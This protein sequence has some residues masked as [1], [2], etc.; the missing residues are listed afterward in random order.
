VQRGQSFPYHGISSAGIKL[1][2]KSLLPS[3]A[4]VD[5]VDTICTSLPEVRLH[6]HLEILGS[7]VGLGLDQHLNI[8]L[9][10]VENRWEIAGS[11][12]GQHGYTSRLFGREKR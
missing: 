1:E 6:V 10:W 9:S 5:N 7:N 12:D 2:L 4:D 11:H 3:L 8:L